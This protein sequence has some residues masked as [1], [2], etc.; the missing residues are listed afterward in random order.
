[1]LCLPAGLTPTE[2]QSAW[3]LGSGAVKL[4]PASLGGPGYVREVRAPL[5]HLRLVPTG[6]VNTETAGPF[7]RAGAFALGVGSA[8]V[9]RALVASGDFAALTER[10][11]RLADA[12]AGAR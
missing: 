12:V 3:V 10:A 4:F 11:R 5:P 7:M 6:G 8:L 1:M 2:L 9:D